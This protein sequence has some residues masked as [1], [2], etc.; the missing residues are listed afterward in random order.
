MKKIVMAM[1]MA[2]VVFGGISTVNAVSATISNSDVNHSFTITRYVTDA[3]AKVTNTFGYTITADNNNPEVI[4]GAPSSATVSFS[5]IAPVDGTAS[6]TGVINLVG[7]TFNKNGDYRYIVTENS[8]TNATM[9]PVDEDN[10]YIIQ[11]SVRNASA[12]DFSSKTVTIT[13][14]KGNDKVTNLEF[15][16]AGV[17]TYISINKTVDGNMADVDEYFKVRV[18]INGETGDTFT[19]AGQSKSGASTTYTVGQTNYIYLK[20][21]ETVTIGKDGNASEI[22][23]GLTYSFIEEDAAEYST[24]INNSESN[25]KQSASLTT[26]ATNTNTITNTYNSPVI[27]GA[28]VKILPYIAIFAVAI[29]GVLYMVI[30]NRKRANIIEE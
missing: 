11:I 17:F 29:A 28:V 6:A 10:T 4:S 12:S 30:R 19:I 18:T 20:H 25:S 16:S 1:I 13:C 7:M 2:F 24:Y 15:T 23:T 27:T 21:G 9:Y 26:A 14:K 8:S 3:K 5:A 22:P